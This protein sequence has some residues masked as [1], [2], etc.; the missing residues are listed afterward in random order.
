MTPA[1]LAS[2]E[3]TLDYVYSMN[4]FDVFLNMGNG[5]TLHLDDF[6]IWFEEYADVT[7]VLDG[8]DLSLDVTHRSFKPGSH[9]PAPNAVP[10]GFKFLGWTETEGSDDCTMVAKAGKY[11][12]YPVVKSLSEL[13][14]E[15]GLL[16]YEAIEDLDA[17]G[18]ARNQRS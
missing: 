12:L 10:A 16:G 2:D 4:Y 5:K 6:E 9:M 7:F 11:T 13:D 14:I 17:S 3:Y 1:G 18:L 15:N 8:T